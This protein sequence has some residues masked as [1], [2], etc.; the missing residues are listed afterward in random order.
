MRDRKTQKMSPAAAAGALAAG[1]LTWQSKIARCGA[2]CTPGAR[3]AGCARCTPSARPQVV[4]PA[5]HDFEKCQH[6]GASR[7]KEGGS[8]SRQRWEVRKVED[9]VG[10]CRFQSYTALLPLAPRL[11]H[12]VL[13]RYGSSKTLHCNKR[14]EGKKI[15]FLLNNFK[16]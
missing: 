10:L 12:S 8:V 5:L 11:I 13:P 2:R 4:R 1:Y 6:I 3:S 14:K 15:S 9:E 7:E 16:L